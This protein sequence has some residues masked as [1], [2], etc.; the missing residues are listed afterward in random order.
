MGPA[1]EPA[2]RCKDARAEAAEEREE[3]VRRVVSS[4][5]FERS[6]RL[7]AFFLHVCRCALDNTPE[8]AT[9]QQVGITVYDRAPGYNPRVRREQRTS[10][11]GASNST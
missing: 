6:F 5:T 1:K 7:R 8:R 10:P 9:E 11:E 3:L 4:S 2:P